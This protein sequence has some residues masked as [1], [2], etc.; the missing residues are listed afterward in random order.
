MKIIIDV[1]RVVRRLLKGQ[2]LTGIDRVTMA[3]VTHYSS[4]AQALMRWWGRSWILS[5]QS[6]KKLFAWL[7]A[8]E[9]NLSVKYLILKGIFNRKQSGG[10]LLNTGHVGLGQTDYLRIKQKQKAKLV[11]VIHD[12]IPINYPEYCSPGEENR[13]REKI[14][15][16]LSLADGIITNSQATQ[17]ELT[18]YSQQ[19]LQPLPQT[20]VALLSSNILKPQTS[21]RPISTPYFV[22]LSTIEPR[23]NHL[24]LLQLWRKLFNQFGHQTPHLFIIGNRGWECENAIDL[25]ERCQALKGVV[26]EIANCPDHDL[27]NYLY[28]AQALLFPSFV[29]GYGLPLIEALTIGTPVIASNLPVF[30]EIAGDIPD[31]IDPLDGKRW[32]ETIIEYAK[33]DSQPRAAQVH[34]LRSFAPPTWI[35]HFKKVDNF[36]KQLSD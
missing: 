4:H 30:R 22:V 35:E 5:P 1:T 17:Q 29:E 25:L 32:E 21:K 13:C 31:Y 7:Q 20:T 24:L 28:H 3:Y 36:L 9:T 33:P 2:M 11:F 18:T 6:S 15:H 26:T 23:K 27:L 10:F 12:L 16:I 34:K 14:R 8:P 19:A